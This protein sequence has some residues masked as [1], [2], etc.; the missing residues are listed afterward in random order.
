MFWVEYTDSMGIFHLYERF[1]ETSPVTIFLG[2]FVQ[3]LNS[4]LGWHC[5][6]RKK[7]TSGVH[8]HILGHVAAIASSHDSV[9]EERP[10]NPP[11]RRHFLPGVSSATVLSLKLNTENHR[12]WAL[13]KK[14]SPWM[15]QK[16]TPWCQS[17]GAVSRGNKDGSSRGEGVGSDLLARPEPH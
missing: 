1:L 2:N 9:Q 14:L 11:L 12:K 17:S 7:A 10:R 5:S 3:V 4:A 6:L 13:M 15:A 16:H 8:G